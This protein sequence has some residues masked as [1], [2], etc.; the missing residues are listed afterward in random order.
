[1]IWWKFWKIG[2]LSVMRDIYDDDIEYVE[3]FI[4]WWELSGRVWRQYYVVVVANVVVKYKTG[5]VYGMAVSERMFLIKVS[6][7]YKPVNAV[8]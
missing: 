2:Y 5:G 7:S 1:M 6:G 3:S 8:C 4:F